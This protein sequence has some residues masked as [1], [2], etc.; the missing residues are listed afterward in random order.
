MGARKCCITGCPSISI[1]PEDRKIT[2]HRFPANN[3]IRDVWI[4]NSRLDPNLHI[5]KSTNVCSRHFLKDDFQDSKGK[6]ILL[7]Q[8]IVPSIFPWSNEEAE[9]PPAPPTKKKRKS[10]ASTSKVA[11]TK[12]TKLVKQNKTTTREEARKNASNSI[13]DAIIPIKKDTEPVKKKTKN[14]HFVAGTKV[15]AQDFNEQWHVAEIMEVDL[16]EREALIHFDKNQLNKSS[17]S[18]EWIPMDSCRLRA[19]SSP[20]TVTETAKSESVKSGT[21]KS[22]IVKPEPLERVNNAP[23]STSKAIKS[24]ASVVTD[25]SV[26][27]VGDKCLARWSDSRKFRATIQKILENGTFSLQICAKNCY[28]YNFYFQIPMKYSL[29][30]VS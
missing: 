17:L 14:I 15:E 27:K 7:K 25:E 23:A 16:D 4:V 26:Y 13:S 21:A 20:L 29:M 9:T 5:T 3:Q 24:A 10:S 22:E 30:M 6:K 19:L 11:D 18:D 2:Y 28:L 12:K 8:N 1:R